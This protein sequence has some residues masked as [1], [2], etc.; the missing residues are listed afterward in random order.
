MLEEGEAS[1]PDGYD[2]AL[3]CFVQADRIAGM[4]NDGSVRTVHIDLP[5]RL[6]DSSG[7]EQ[8]VQRPA[9]VCIRRVGG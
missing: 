1:L 8:S 7:G 2:R 6:D 3:H 9:R 5:G 4:R